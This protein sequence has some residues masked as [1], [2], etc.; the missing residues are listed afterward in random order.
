MDYQL[1]AIVTTFLLLGLVMVF[2]ASFVTVGTQFFLAQIKWVVV[3]VAGLRS[4]WQPFPTI[5][6]RSSPSRSWARPSSC[7]SRC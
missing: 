2:S 7:W 4:S 1:I 3:G 6:G 5:G